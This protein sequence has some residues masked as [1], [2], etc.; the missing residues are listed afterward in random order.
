MQ[1]T[2]EVDGETGW[3][4]VTV[5]GDIGLH[6]LPSLAAAVWGDPSYA[7]VE[8]AIWNFVQTRSTMR[9]DD[10]M[11]LTQWISE[12]KRGRG[13]RTVAIVAAEDGVF[14]TGRMF[15]ALQRQSGWNVG[16]FRDEEAATR[17]LR[18]QT[19][20]GEGRCDER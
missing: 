9:L 18:E 17:W 14:G 19:P 15:E 4:R 8:R 11:R 13:A 5:R 12:N 2:I 20:H 3:G 16:V 1:Y 10:M 7:R 6:E